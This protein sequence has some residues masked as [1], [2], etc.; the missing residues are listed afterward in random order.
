MLFYRCWGDSRTKDGNYDNA[1]E[2]YEFLLKHDKG[3]EWL[4]KHHPWLVDYF[5][6][7]GLEEFF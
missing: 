6:S 1:K 4:D 5:E 2:W 7:T 3:R